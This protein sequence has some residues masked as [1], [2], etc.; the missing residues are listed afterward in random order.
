[1]AKRSLKSYEN[2]AII[3]QSLPDKMDFS[4]L[5]GNCNPVHLEIGSGKG[6]FLVNQAKEY[7][8]IN[9]LGIEWANKFY[10]YAVDRIGRWGLTNVRLLR[11]DAAVFISEKIPGCSVACCHIYFPDPWHKRKHNN[12]RFVSYNNLLQLHRILSN[13]GIINI[14]TDHKDYYTWMLKEFDKTGS[15]FVETDYIVPVG[16]ANDELTGTNFERK[17]LKQG[18]QTYTLAMKKN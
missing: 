3:K 8:D 17:Y 13:G 9:Y 11:D 10:L 4:E 16:A 2:V 18:R 15:L 14:A 6:T 1:M 12:R 7:P 5:F